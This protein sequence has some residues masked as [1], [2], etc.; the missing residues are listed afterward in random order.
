MEISVE[1]SSGMAPDTDRNIYRNNVK[2][3]GKYHWKI[4][5]QYSDLLLSSDKNIAGL[6]EKPLKDIYR[7]L[8]KCFK[9]DP[10][11]LR[12]LSPVRINPGY[13]E[14]IKKMCLLSAE[15]N[16]GPMAAVAGTVNEFLAER[17][18][19]YCGNLII[20]NG[21]DLYLRSKNDRILGI[22]VKNK[23]FKD[24]ISIRIKAA[25]MPCG[26]C[27]SSGTFGHS[28][29]LGKCDLAV[30]MSKSAITADAAA[31]AVAN[32]ISCKDDI[33]ASIE[34]FRNCRGIDGLLLIKE[35]QIGLWGNIELV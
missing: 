2:T 19:K 29:S 12:S 34:H 15:F 28:L 26:V 22:Y 35:D 17:I 23:Y 31:T 4:T 21:G 25:N 24:S 8:N 20:E 18:N 3:G 5:Y 32:S 30:V 14:I 33:L 13:P 11:F 6:I 1:N 27:A 10:V 9:E 7:Y 16:V